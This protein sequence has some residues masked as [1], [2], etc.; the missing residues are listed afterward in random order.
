MR[1]NPHLQYAK[2]LVETQYDAGVP[3][4]Q[5]V[6][7]RKLAFAA[8]DK[9]LQLQGFLTHKRSLPMVGSTLLGPKGPARVSRSDVGWFRRSSAEQKA[10]LPLDAGV[11]VRPSSEEPLRG[12]LADDLYRVRLP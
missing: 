11:V 9:A 12:Y 6:A 5:V 8:V 4:I 1:E 7:Y 3:V 10:A 2:R